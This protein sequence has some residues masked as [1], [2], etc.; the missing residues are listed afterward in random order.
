MENIIYTNIIKSPIGDLFAA[1]INQELIILSYYEKDIAKEQIK[2]LQKEYKYTEVIENKKDFELLEK[3]LDEYF[4]HHRTSFTVPF[5]VSGTT[6]QKDVWKVLSKIPYGKT[7]SYKEEA[8]SINKASAFR[9]VAN[10][11]GKNKI[12][13]IIPC[14]RVISSSGKL[15]GYSSGG[16]KV[17]EFLIN[18]EKKKILF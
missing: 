2:L 4:H 17:K 7:I 3:E 12:I 14:H 6:F 10:A 5:K 16:P 8:I 13:I 1:N 9:A 15:S 18:L 11:N